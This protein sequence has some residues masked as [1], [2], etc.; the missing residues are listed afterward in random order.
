LAFLRRE[1]TN[2]EEGENLNK[3]ILTLLSDMK[4]TNLYANKDFNYK[5][6]YAADISHLNGNT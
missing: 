3:K 6:L 5:T 4:M 2:K 1:Q